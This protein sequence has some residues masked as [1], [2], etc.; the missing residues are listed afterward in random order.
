MN[1]NRKIT[2]TALAAALE[3]AISCDVGTKGLG[4]L[5]YGWIHKYGFVTPAVL[6]Q[7]RHMDGE[8]WLTV[9]ETASFSEY[10][11]YDLNQQTV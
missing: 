4:I 2:F 7:R 3:R 6:R 9:Q 8:A 5:L 10:A 1:E 11:G